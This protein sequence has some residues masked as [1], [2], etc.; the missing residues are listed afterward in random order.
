M[1]RSFKRV[2]LLRYDSKVKTVSWFF[3][4]GLSRVRFT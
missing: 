4:N 3:R 1:T 2:K